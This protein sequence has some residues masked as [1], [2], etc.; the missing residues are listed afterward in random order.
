VKRVRLCV[1]CCGNFVEWKIKGFNT[2]VKKAV[3]LSSVGD[4]VFWPVGHN[5]S[6]PTVRTEEKIRAEQ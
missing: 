6:S 4:W 1:D 2:F 3:L 5:F